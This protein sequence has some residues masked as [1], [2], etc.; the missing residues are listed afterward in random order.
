MLHT[1]T[2]ID[3]VAEMGTE[4]VCYCTCVHTIS[5]NMHVNGFFD[6]SSVL[7]VLEVGSNDH[8]HCTQYLRRW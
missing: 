5:I 6:T 4:S 3:D 2:D 7:N 1:Y 8:T